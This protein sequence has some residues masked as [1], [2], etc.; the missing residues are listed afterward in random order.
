MSS[1]YVENEALEIDLRVL[2]ED[3][4]RGAKRLLWLGALLVALGAALFAFRTWRSYRPVYRA[5]AS[6]TVSVSNPL[7]SGSR[8]YNASTAEQMEKTFPYI[9]TSGALSDRVRERLGL[10]AL[11]AISASALKSTNIFTLSVTSEDPQLAYEVLNATIECYPEVAEFVVGPTE[12]ELLDET[13]VPTQPVTQRDYTASV[14]KGAVVGAALWVA[15]VVGLA[16]L[17]STVHNEKELEQLV[18]LRCLGVLPEARGHGGRRRGEERPLL[19]TEHDVSGFGES[20]RLLRIRVEKELRQREQKVLLVSSAVPGEG[21]TTVAANLAVALAQKGKRTLLMDCDL[22]NPSVAAMFGKED[23]KG[24]SAYLEREAAADEIIHPMEPKNFCAVFGGK[25][26]ANAT[27]LLARQE[28][29][30]LIEA[31]RAVFDYIILD[32]PP[33]SLL[34]DAAELAELADCAVMVIRQNTA[35]RS[36]I[37]D[38][39]QLLAD[40]GLPLMGCVLNGA[41]GLSLHDGYSYYGYGKYGGSYS[42]S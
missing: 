9:L 35:S 29:R 30:E 28:A 10:A 24:L 41:R 15:L 3:V 21:K 34:A 19:V 16:L 31:A 27:E 22:R 13:G 8:T 42:G 23:G 36:R 18:N 40:S 38:G 7:Y 11:P 1:E 17:R 32:T 20:L 2:T 25:P 5:S 26:V 33:S 4:L 39:V 14:K 12:M 37:L 6:F